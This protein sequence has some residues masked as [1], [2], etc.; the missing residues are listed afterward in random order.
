[1]NAPLSAIAP[2]TLAE[3]S[4]V[5]IDA[6]SHVGRLSLR[7]R[8]DLS[9]LNEAL[10]MVLPT[11]IGATVRGPIEVACLGPDEWVILAPP[12]E[13]ERLQSACAAIYSSHPHSLVD[14]GGR[15]V[16]FTL[17]GP[18]AAEL[19]TLGC[20]RDIDAI[21]NASARRTLFDG[22]TVILWRDADDR[23]RM[24]V[25]NSF[26]PHVLHLLKTGCRELAAEIA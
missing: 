8:G 24:D 23:F 9:A 13:V 14:T 11:R 19:L 21:A 10:G 4:A 12:G 17:T 22:A 16:T 5:R 25:W 2:M 1:M 3:S 7:A 20:P 26:A 18:R 15:E 6:G